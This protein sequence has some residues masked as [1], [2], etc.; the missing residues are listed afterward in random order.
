[1]NIY[2]STELL[3][4]INELLNNQNTN[5]ANNTPIDDLDI[6]INRRVKAKLQATKKGKCHESQESHNE[7]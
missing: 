4:V 2:E 3:N 6:L 5:I 1:M 7:R